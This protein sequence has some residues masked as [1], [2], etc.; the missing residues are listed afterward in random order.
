MLL[1]S[2]FPGYGFGGFQQGFINII[3]GF[4]LGYSVGHYCLGLKM[5][6]GYGLVSANAKGN[7]GLHYTVNFDGVMCESSCANATD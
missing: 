3:S 6:F 5:I 4:H 7:A 2:I 1:Q